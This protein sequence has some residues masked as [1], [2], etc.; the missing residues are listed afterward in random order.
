MIL[1]VN[2]EG[3]CVEVEGTPSAPLTERVEHLQRKGYR[4]ATPREQETYYASKRK[5][6][7]LHE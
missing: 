7:A 3:K 5:A 4:L 6:T 1:L 2:K